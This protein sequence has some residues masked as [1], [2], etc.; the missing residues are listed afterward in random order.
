MQ[1]LTCNYIFCAR[2]HC[3]PPLPLANCAPKPYWPPCSSLCL[4]GTSLP[5][6]L[7]TNKSLHLK[8]SF[9]TYPEFR[10]PYRILP[11]VTWSL[12]VDFNPPIAKLSQPPTHTQ[13]SFTLLYFIMILYAVEFI[14]F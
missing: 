3:L 5:E 14:T 2:R 1:V 11:L 6:G 12:L 9:P 10:L 13:H 4:A 8:S 7:S